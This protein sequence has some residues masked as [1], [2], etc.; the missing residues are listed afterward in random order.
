MRDGGNGQT[1]P[2]GTPPAEFAAFVR[3][4]FADYA[5]YTALAQSA[6]REFET[7][8][9]WGV[10]GATAM[11]HLRALLEKRRRDRPSP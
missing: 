6:F 9:N 8:L 7:R 10:S 4:H 2:L 5:R 1:F 11:G 3:A